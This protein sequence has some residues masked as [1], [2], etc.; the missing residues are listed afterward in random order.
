M[1]VVVGEDTK[2]GGVK[3]RRGAGGR[4][5]EGRG[6]DTMRGNLTQHELDMAMQP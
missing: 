6:E 2:R 3:T 4:H 5:E 1:F